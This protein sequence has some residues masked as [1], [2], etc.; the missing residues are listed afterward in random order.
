MRP[1]NAR[2]TTEINS[3][4]ATFTPLVMPTIPLLSRTRAV[5]I[6]VIESD[7]QN[8]Q[9]KSGLCRGMERHVDADG[10]SGWIKHEDVAP[11]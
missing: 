3:A 9:R 2:P 8:L 10:G 5:I 6:N 11:E 4:H 1:Q 7:V